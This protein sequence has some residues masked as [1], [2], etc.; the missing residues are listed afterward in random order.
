MKRF[1]MFGP[2]LNAIESA[3]ELTSPSFHPDRCQ[4]EPVTSPLVLI[5]GREISE[6]VGVRGPAFGAGRTYSHAIDR[7]GGVPVIVPPLEF[8][9]ESVRTVIDRVDALVLHGGGDID[10]AR[11][12]QDPTTDELY[13]IN[14]R[15]D[16]A[17]LAI[18]TAALDRGRPVLAI[19][20][21]L[22][23]M[24]VALGG[25][26]VQ[27]L[28]VPDHRREFHPVELLP[29]CRVA[30]AMGTNHP[31]RCHSFHH[32]AIDELG[33]GLQIVGR[34]ADGTIEAVEKSGDAWVVGVQ[35]HPEDN[36]ESESDQQGLFDELVRR[37]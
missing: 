17:E 4:N 1:F 7:A 29:E 37:A 2:W 3:N 30:A 36:A 35:W 18:I 32:Q 27:H 22:Q 31:Q 6:A 11:Y 34:H 12:G 13:G 14:A 19:C 28:E 26:L 15:H 10:P 24:N 21:G 9:A 8:A 16:A 25:T 23:I 33:D 20:R 5:V